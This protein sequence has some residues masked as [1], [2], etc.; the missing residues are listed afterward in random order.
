MRTRPVA[1]FADPASE[2]VP[3]NY[4]ALKAACEA[5]VRSRFGERASVVRPGLI[6]GPHDPTD[7]FAYWPARFVHPHLLGSRAPRAVVPAPPARPI[8]VIDA[9]DLAAFT[10]GLVER[11]VAGTFNACSP[12]GRFAFRDLVDAC[13][14]VSASPPAPAWTGEATLAAHHV[15]PWTGLPLWIPAT[16]A[17]AAGFMSIGTSRA[18]QEGLVARALV[19]T[20]RDTAAWLLQRDNAGAWKVVLSDARERLVLSALAG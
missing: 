20:V 14:A 9:R 2:D 10:L 1:P 15:E 5:V 11:E 6:V 19:D 12:P 4:G 17:D 16:E 13:L 3:R 18:E 7:R 8:Q